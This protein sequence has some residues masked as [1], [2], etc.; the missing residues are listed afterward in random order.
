MR[1]YKELT[2]ASKSYDKQISRIANRYRQS[3]LIPFCNKYKIKFISGD[4]GFVFTPAPP[5]NKEYE[6][7][8]DS[9]ME[10][11]EYFTSPIGSWMKSYTPEGWHQ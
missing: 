2:K 5:D 3:H 9:L 7:L 1:I 11:P 10:I 4:G 8:M 6:E